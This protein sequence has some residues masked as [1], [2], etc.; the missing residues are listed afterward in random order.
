MGEIHIENLPEAQQQLLILM[1]EQLKLIK[2]E[3]M[4][5]RYSEN[6][7]MRCVIWARIMP[8]LYKDLLKTSGLI[9]HHGHE[10]EDL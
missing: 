5:R 2:Q 9:C 7:L 10:L 8:K 1:K 4:T 3:P 6:L